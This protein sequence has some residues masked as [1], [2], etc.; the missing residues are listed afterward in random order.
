MGLHLYETTRVY[1]TNHLLLNIV[2]SSHYPPPPIAMNIPEH[3]T[4]HAIWIICLDNIL[5]REVEEP[6]GMYI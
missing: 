1:L 5:R 3:V 4:L 2:S 6:N